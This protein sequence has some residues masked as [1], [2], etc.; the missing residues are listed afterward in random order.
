MPS[1]T[2]RVDTLASQIEVS[3]LADLTSISQATMT[4]V[5]RGDMTP[6]EANRVS[7]VVRRRM[8]VIEGELRERP[9]LQ[10]R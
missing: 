9:S 5:L 10:P 8:K 6:K 3:T 2:K 1:T 7:K 4:A